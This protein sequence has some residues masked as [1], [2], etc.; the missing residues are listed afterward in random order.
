[1]LRA[2]NG[3]SIAADGDCRSYLFQAVEHRGMADVPGMQDEPDVCPAK[4]IDDWIQGTSCLSRGYVRV[5]HHSEENR[6]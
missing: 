3:F 5:A 1:M 4:K 6:R 2:L